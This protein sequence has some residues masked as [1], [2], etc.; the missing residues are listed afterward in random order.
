[1]NIFIMYVIRACTV[2]FE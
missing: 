2:W 1:V